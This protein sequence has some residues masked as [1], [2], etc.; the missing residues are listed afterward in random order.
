VQGLRTSVGIKVL[1]G[2]VVLA[3]AALL[4]STAPA[5]TTYVNR[6]ERTVRLA[7]GGTATVELT[8]TRVG[9][10]TLTV[11]VQGRAA[12]AAKVT[13]TLALPS[14][15]YGP[16]PVPLRRV[17]AGRFSTTSASLPRAGAW[18]LVVRVQTSE[19]DSDGAEGTVLGA[20][21]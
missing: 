21:R 5:R 3:L 8:P 7:S 15:R 16:L 4:V 13:A 1:L 18:R 11:T 10:N 20:A 9:S 14:D 17:G 2:A 6:V 12:A 19:F